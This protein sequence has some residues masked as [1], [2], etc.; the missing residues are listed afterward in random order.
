MT[1]LPPLPRVV[2]INRRRAIPVDPADL[3]L[4]YKM[5]VLNIGLGLINLAATAW[6]LIHG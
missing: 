3:R 2:A 1:S 5:L 4:L 6:G